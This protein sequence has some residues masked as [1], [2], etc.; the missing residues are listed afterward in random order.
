MTTQTDTIPIWRLKLTRR[1]VL[2][3]GLKAGVGAAALTALG[4]SDATSLPPGSRAQARHGGGVQ[5]GGEAIAPFVGPFS[6]NPHT[7]D[8]YESL[9]YRTQIASGYHYSRLIRPVSAGPGVSPIESSRFQ[10]DLT[11]VP[12]TPDS[13]TYVFEL[14]QGARWHDVDP[15][16]GRR[17]S[18]SDITFSYERYQQ[19]SPNAPRW[20]SHVEGLTAQADT[21]TVR[22]REPFAPLLTLVGSAQDLWILPQE[23]V[24]DGTIA[25]RP[26]GSGA[27]VFRSFEPDV[28]IQWRRNPDWHGAGRERLPILDRMTVTMNGASDVIV[29]ALGEGDLDFSQLSPSLYESAR[30]AA[31]DAQFVFTPNTILGGFFFNFSIPPWNDVRVRQAL[32]LALD[33]DA[34]LRWVDPTG[35]GAWQTALAQL[36]PYWLDPQDL[37]RFGRSYNGMPSGSLFHRD[38]SRARQLLDAAGY[39]DGVQAV[40]HGTADYGASV[41]NLYEACAASVSEAGFR[42]E[43]FFKEFAPYIASIFRG[44]FPD[45]WDGETSHLAIGP[46]YAGANDPDDIL[47]AVYD[48]ESNRHNWGASGRWRRGA[49]S[50][51]DPG[52]YGEAWSHA[53]AARG[54]GP[55]ADET[56]HAMI[57]R[58]REILEADERREYINDIQR[59]LATQMYIVPYVAVPGV[60]A[61]N[62]WVHYRDADRV[63]MKSTYGMGQE[64]VTGL[65]IDQAG[66]PGG[67]GSAS[68]TMTPARGQV[69]EVRIVARRL[70][71]G[72]IEFGLRPKGL[73]SLLPRSRYFPA[74]ARTGSWLQS[75][76]VVLGSEVLGRIRARRLSDGRTEFGFVDSAGLPIT[77][78]VRFFPLGAPANTWLQSSAFDVAN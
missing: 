30:A 50:H 65:W 34:V 44:N 29:P 68:G 13:R 42:F 12:E 31:P 5:R 63:H 56:L 11:S 67:E 46:L 64:F 71:D 55:E 32:S 47:S 52:G 69:I 19:L 60:H 8:P 45:A 58:Q 33:R 36:E 24:D 57:R 73:T 10:A 27:W 28:S 76:S 49:Q 9:H 39:P 16:N 48:R 3:A 62:R 53:S 77:P 40:V 43:F 37:A 61:Y 59:Y 23:T 21:V 14:N 1:Q 78:K 70:A 51:L 72:R 66:R 35:R 26:V 7:F 17:V 41:V 15:L 75:S 25:L 20:N 74:N 4:L 38:L 18:T 22:T 6:G 2:Q 54:G